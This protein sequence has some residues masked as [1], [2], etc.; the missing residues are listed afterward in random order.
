MKRPSSRPQQVN[1]RG[2]VQQTAAWAGAAAVAPLLLLS[3]KTGNDKPVIGPQGFQFRCNHNYFQLPADHQYGQASH[4][5]CVDKAGHIYISHQGNPGSIFVFDP[6]GKFIRSLSPEFSGHGHGIDIREENGQEFLYLSPADPKLGFSKIDLRGETAWYKT[7]DT[8]RQETGKYKEDNPRFRP[9]NTSF[10]PDGGF[11]LGDGYGSNFIHQYDAS[12]KFLR[13]IGGSGT[14]DGQFNTP[15]G[16]WLDS[17]DGT[18]KL[19]VCDRANKRLQFFDMQ[20]QF[21]SKLEGLL[22]PADIDIQGD[23][24][25][26]PDLHAR[27]TLLDKQ[28]QVV[29]QLGDDPD[30]RAQV[31]ADNFQMRGQPERW[32]PGKFIHP[33]DACFDS[34]GNLIVAEWVVGGRV[35]MLQK[36]DG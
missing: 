3:K 28:N 20:G 27:I 9:T 13:T 22:F 24:M 25:V 17:R 1:R 11:F 7:F 19:A 35:T 21:L 30:W 5:V 18:P 23:L 33:H 31:L 15:H 36:V 10:S 29:A 2:F 8:I 32:L 16:Q 6:D 26:V 34:R 14:A 12:G 4:G